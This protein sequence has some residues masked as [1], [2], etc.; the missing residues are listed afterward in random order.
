[1]IIQFYYIYM[2]HK[3]DTQK[4]RLKFIYQIVIVI[5]QLINQIEEK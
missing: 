4:Y 5:Y 2:I 1:M 3:I